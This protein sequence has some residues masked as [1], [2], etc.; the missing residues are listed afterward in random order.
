[1]KKILFGTLLFI[2]VTFTTQYISHF[3]LNVEHYEAVSFT[4]KEVIFPLGFLTM[5][6]QGAVLSFFFPL[7]SKGKYTLVKGF[8]FG[9][10]MSALFVSY[11]T[12][13]EPAKYQ[14]PNIVSWV[15]VEGLVGLTQ[16]CTYGTL[17]SLLY[18]RLK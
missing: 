12:F 11:P 18:S 10:L 4:R 6:L 17:L 16:F 5:I 3:V 14:V 8:L 13:T 9:L 1:M 7:F 15:I 2:L